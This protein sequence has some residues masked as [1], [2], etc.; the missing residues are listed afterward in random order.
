MSKS[1]MHLV[2]TSFIKIQELF[3]P[4]IGDILQH[5]HIQEDREFKNHQL[6]RSGEV[7]PTTRKDSAWRRRWFTQKKGNSY[8]R[9]WFIYHGPGPPK[10][11]SQ[12]AK[13][14]KL[15]PITIHRNHATLEVDWWSSST[16]NHPSVEHKRAPAG[17]IVVSW[18]SKRWN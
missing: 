13:L 12:W 1:K 4:I 5:E 9:T 8:H 6:L 14:L 18:S 17:M 11:L 15:V 2:D 10:R 3:A 16:T 7:S